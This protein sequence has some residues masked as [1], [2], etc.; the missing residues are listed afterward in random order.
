MTL[1]EKLQ[2]YIFIQSM[3]KC[4]IWTGCISH[5]RGY[6]RWNGKMRLASR[7]SAVA[8]FL[9]DPEHN[10]FKFDNKYLVLHRCHNSRCINPNHLYIGTYSDNM[11]DR[12]RAGNA[13]DLRGEKHSQCKLSAEDVRQVRTL[14]QQRIPQRKIAKQFGVSQS[15]I[16]YINTGKAR[17]EVS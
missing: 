2:Q 10:D 1:V 12:Q 16:C 7:A 9:Q 6:V 14:L 13:P 3:T 5:N 17:R 4:W 15:Q 8:F 11:Y